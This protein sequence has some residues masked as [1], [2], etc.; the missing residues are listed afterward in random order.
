M[1]TRV[2]SSDLDRFAGVLAPLGAGASH[3]IWLVTLL[4]LAAGFRGGSARAG[5]L[6]AVE[7]EL[8]KDAY[9]VVFKDDVS[10]SI[11]IEA[12][13]E[14]NGFHLRKRWRSALNAVLVEGVGPKL[15]A[16]LARR[17]EVAWVEPD[18]VIRVEVD[19]GTNPGEPSNQT[20]SWGLDRLDQR[21][22]P[23]DGRYLPPSFG[24]DFPVYVLDSGI[25]AGHREF[26]GRARAVHD[27]FDPRHGGVDCNGHGTHVAG[28]IAGARF[29]VARQARI[30][31]IRVLDCSG[32]GAW[33]GLIDG[34]EWLLQHA[35][36]PAVV[37]LSLGGNGGVSVDAAVN[38][39]AEAGFLVVASA[40]N[41]HGADSCRHTPARA[42]GAL[43]VAAVDRSD[44]VAGFSSLGSCVDL[45]A[46]G[47][48]IP[49]AWFHSDSASRILNGTSMA[50]PHVAGLA[51]MLW[52][53]FPEWRVDQVRETLLVSSTPGL[54]TGHLGGAPN[55]LAHAHE[56]EAPPD[57]PGQPGY[58]QV[59]PM[60]CYGHF[61]L[62]WP[63]VTGATHYE[64]YVSD[65]ADFAVSELFYS[66]PA[67]YRTL[68][69]SR[70]R[71]FRVR[72]CHA[73]A[74][75]PFRAGDRVAQPINICF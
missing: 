48:D 50:A 33:S 15:I 39:V 69:V 13:A 68:M 71:Y 66:G 54:I 43:T 52:G 64:L 3:T 61:Y 29:G 75:G 47:V 14:A 32:T 63:A 2:F 1:N 24:R 67:T 30:Y 55:R 12:L 4:V 9:I 28:T 8:R 72:A 42:Q 25:R 18:A 60:W 21:R 46:P 6:I 56:V 44:R 51:A 38:R 35:E 36:P 17:S 34:L 41:D 16:Q 58:L 45:F 20:L 57:P 74:C 26:E 70:S 59:L 10:P 37:N 40:G 62:R 11:A 19:V 65:S 5:E 53:R 23:L 7:G 73:F 49:S 22:L 31:A 27:V